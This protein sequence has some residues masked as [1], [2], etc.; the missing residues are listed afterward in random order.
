MTAES[1]AK[2]KAD[3]KS[4]ETQ[5]LEELAKKKASEFQ[6]MKAGMK[7]GMVFSGKDLFDFNPEWADH[8][9]DEAME[10]YE[11]QESD[12]EENE[13]LAKQEKPVDQDLFGD[14][15]LEGLDSEDEN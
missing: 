12:H 15:Q 5:E 11:R 9:D 13:V 2:W 6:R 7:T 14:D 1:F 3:R 8:G 10:T 4:K